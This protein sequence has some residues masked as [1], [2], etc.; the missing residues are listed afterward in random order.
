[1]Q[2]PRR[3]RISASLLAINAP[4][5]SWNTTATTS[6]LRM[7]Y[8]TGRPA[9]TVVDLQELLPYGGHYQRRDK[10]DLI[11]LGYITVAMALAKA[12]NA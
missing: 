3:I 2:K 9:V 4:D 1:M 10:P 11:S 7:A 8:R 6:H 12:L 5:A